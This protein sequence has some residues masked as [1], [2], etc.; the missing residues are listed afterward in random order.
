MQKGDILG[1]E[2][3]GVVDQV[4]PNV[5][6]LTPGQRVV[7]SFQIACGECEFCKNNISSM[8]DRTNDSS[9]VS[10]TFDKSQL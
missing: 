8:C 1:H 7:A 4:G 3:M 9:F 10:S 2:F 6:N 5:H